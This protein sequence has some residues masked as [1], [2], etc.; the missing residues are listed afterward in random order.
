MSRFN[1]A[2]V[3]SCTLVGLLGGIAVSVLTATSMT[4]MLLLGG[5]YGLLFALLCVR[6]VSTVGAG[7]LWGLGYAILCW[8]VVPTALAAAFQMHAMAQ[9][10]DS[11]RSHFPELVAYLL[12]FGLP[13]GLVLGCWNAY[14]ERAMS[15][16]SSL[17][18]AIIVGGLSGL[19]GGWF[20][21]RWLGQT[22]SFVLIAGLV[23]STSAP[24]GMLVHYIIA[25][26]IG[27]GFGLLFQRDIRGYGSSIGWGLAYGLLWWFL[28]SLTLLAVLRGQRLD[29]SY[30]YAQSYFGTFVGHAIYGIV[31][32][33]IYAF[34]DRLW[35]GFFIEADPIK[36]EFRGRATQTLRV[37]VWGAIASLAGG[38]VFSIIML[39][40]G[41]LPRIAA[42]AGGSSLALGFVVHFVISVLIGM[43]YGLFYQHE[44][45]DVGSSIAWGLLY[46]LVWW[47]VGPLTLLPILLGGTA[48]WTVASANILLPSLIGHLIYGAVTACV[49]LLFERHQAAQWRF[50]QRQVAR[51]AALQRPVG[52]PVPALW[53]VVLAIGIILPIVLG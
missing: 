13:L 6:R 42:L 2:K 7:L 26:I 23:G 4:A 34:L 22:H 24:L 45:P 20:F 36:R 10:L 37:L 46:G 35:Q 17:L 39:V 25:V 53:F 41:V 15:D 9:M 12:L 31:L 14:Q 16:R 40:T 11:A 19:V 30:Q 49:F 21:G 28:G 44:A 48:T 8:L 32:G 27:V 51:T 3:L 50:D 29:W 18:R 52:T 1:L 47:F 43:S 38:L 5:L 33:L